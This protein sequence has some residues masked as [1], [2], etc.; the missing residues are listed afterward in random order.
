MSSADEIYCFHWPARFPRNRYAAKPL[1]SE[2]CVV[3]AQRIDIRRMAAH[4][5][6]FAGWRS[7]PL[8]RFCH[9]QK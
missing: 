2:R 6:D 5:Y 9:G 7:C 8:Q 3:C 1:P 4:Q